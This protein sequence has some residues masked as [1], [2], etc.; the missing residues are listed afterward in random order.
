MVANRTGY[1]PI[2]FNMTYLP[3]DDN[4]SMFNIRVSVQPL[5]WP[6]K[7]TYLKQSWVTRELAVSTKALTRY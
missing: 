6:F 1:P 7:G 5:W 3:V 2:D 4:N